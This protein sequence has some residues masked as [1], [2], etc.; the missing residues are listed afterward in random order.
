L[1]PEAPITAGPVVIPPMLS[2]VAIVTVSA[3]T[4]VGVSLMTRPPAEPVLEK[5]FDPGD[6]TEA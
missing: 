5:Y 6:A 3:V 1:F 4:L 2:V